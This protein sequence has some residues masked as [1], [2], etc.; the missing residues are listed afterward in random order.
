MILSGYLRRSC[1]QHA[2]LPPTPF[3]ETRAAG[4]EDGD[5]GG[6]G[7]GNE[8]GSE[9]S[10][11]RGSGDTGRDEGDDAG[12]KSHLKTHRPKIFFSRCARV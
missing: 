11:V 3:A 2:A 6:S 7:H 1:L 4:G 9:R 5:K 8:G 12:V 10:E